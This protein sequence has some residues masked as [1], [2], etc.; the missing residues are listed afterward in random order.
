[1]HI[2]EVVRIVQE[3]LMGFGM[4]IALLSSVQYLIQVTCGTTETNSFTR[5][6]LMVAFGLNLYGVMTASKSSI[7]AITF[8]WIFMVQGV[9]TFGLSVRPYASLALHF[10]KRS[11]MRL[12]S[13]R[14]RCRHVAVSTKM[15]TR[16]SKIQMIFNS[17]CLSVAVIGALISTFT[18]NSILSVGCAVTADLSAYLPSIRGLFRR[19]LKMQA[20]PYLLGATSALLTLTSPVFS[21]SS[22]LQIYLVFMDGVVVYGVCRD[23][24][25]WRQTIKKEML[26]L[27]PT[28]FYQRWQEARRQTAT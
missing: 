6:G 23:D 9:W 18:H 28:R 14:E 10:L 27:L 7:A 21:F 19:R 13:A 3:I 16:E 2:L 22:T 15:R 24:K 1:M 8:A 20:G 4:F 25:D 12:L 26:D 11:A 5:L 17:A